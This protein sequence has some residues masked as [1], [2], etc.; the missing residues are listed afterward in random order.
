MSHVTVYRN[1]EQID[2]IEFTRHFYIEV[3]DQ[4][5]AIFWRDD[6]TQDWHFDEAHGLSYEDSH[7]PYLHI[8]LQGSE[9]LQSYTL[10]LLRQDW[11]LDVEGQ[12]CQEGFYDALSIIWRE[13]S[14]QYQAY[15]FDFVF[16]YL[17]TNTQAPLPKPVKTRDQLNHSS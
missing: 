7:R 13:V 2:Y 6:D 3:S 17:K 4:D 10:P 16:G 14:L 9:N 12:R 15:R 11:T 5:N 1:K 8:W